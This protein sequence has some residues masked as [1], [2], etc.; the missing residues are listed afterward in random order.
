MAQSRR[1]LGVRDRNMT[2]A[3]FLAWTHLAQI[4]WT[5]P[6]DESDGATLTLTPLREAA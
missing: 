5:S 6:S 2:G 3:G 4:W 1:G